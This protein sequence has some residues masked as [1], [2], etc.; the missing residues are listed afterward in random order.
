MTL[1]HRSVVSV[2]L[3][4]HDIYASEPYRVLLFRRSEKVRTY[5]NKLGPIAGSIDESDAS[6]LQAAWRELK[7][8][9]GLGPDNTDLWRRGPS[10]EFTD[11]TAVSAKRGRIWK[12]WPF[13]FR[14]KGPLSVQDPHDDGIHLQIDWEHTGYEWKTI[15][16]IL[17]G[18][19]LEEC[20]PRL[21]V[22]L[23]HLW[24]DPKS[25]LLQGLEQLRLDHDHGAR[26]LATLA[27]EILVSIA[28]DQ[29]HDDALPDLGDWWRNLKLQAFHLAFN[30]RPS[31]AAAISKAVATALARVHDITKAGL[32][33][34]KVRNSL[35]TY[36]RERSGISQRV[37]EH[38][39][40]FLRCRFGSATADSGQPKCI[41]LLTMSSSSTVKHALLNALDTDPNLRIELR[42]LESRPLFEGVKFANALVMEAQTRRVDGGSKPILHDRLRIVLATDASVAVLC[43]DV[44]L[45]IIGAD[46]ISQSGDVSNKTGSLPLVLTSKAMSPISTSVVC[47]SETDKI[48]PPEPI[49]DHA[50]ED[51]DAGEITKGWDMQD[52]T[53]ESSWLD[54]VKV[55]NIYFEWIPA[56]LIDVYICETGILK[57]ADIHQESND[58]AKLIDEI[59]ADVWKG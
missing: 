10:F 2:L 53:D 50:Q 52:R 14:L 34:P 19:I 21:E 43:K 27:V 51:N 36:V 22:T 41:K 44:D 12:V 37:A 57:A 33:R 39:A 13:A 32:D 38:F 23:K 8:E 17:S 54:M 5:Q 25:E 24:V 9:T 7:E 47:I 59:F 11:E 48:A 3:F 28:R 56:R 46:R 20:V 6:P 26:E 45:V 18:K 31:M 42:V 1:E 16:E 35:S 49:E 29:I 58:V 55:R 15:D 4:P 40:I 30:A